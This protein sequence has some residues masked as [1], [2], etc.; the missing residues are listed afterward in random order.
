MGYVLIAAGFEGISFY[1]SRNGI[2]N[3]TFFH[4]FVIAQLFLFS[5]IYYTS[6]DSPRVKKAIQGITFIFLLLTLIILTL[7]SFQEFNPSVKGVQNLIILSYSILYFYHLS[8]RL[9]TQRLELLPMF[10][11]NSGVLLY[12]AGT[13]LVFTLKEY[14][15]SKEGKYIIDLW[16]FHLFLNVILNVLFAIGF[17][18]SRQKY[19][20]A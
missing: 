9:P 8:D 18:V 5:A 2:H 19:L 15:G 12:F 7:N 14:L 1:T 6:F 17:W 4:T 11:I 16:D 20:T 13:L 10:W 3:I